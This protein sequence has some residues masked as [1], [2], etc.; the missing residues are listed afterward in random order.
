MAMKKFPMFLVVGTGSVNHGQIQLTMY[1]PSLKADSTAHLIGTR[2]LKK[3]ECEF[4]VPDFDLRSM[5]IEALEK[6]V[7]AEKAD[8]QVRVNI[9]LDRISKLKAITHEVAQ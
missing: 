7:I 3:V 9:L 5:E 4:D 2:L 1:E 6:S 8:S